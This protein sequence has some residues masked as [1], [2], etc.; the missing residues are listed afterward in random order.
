MIHLINSFRFS[1]D[2][3]LL[4]F[5]YLA[6][7]LSSFPTHILKSIGVISPLI[8]NIMLLITSILGLYF[9]SG[10]NYYIWNTFI[11]KNVSK[12]NFLNITKIY[13]KKFV[14]VLVFVL[15]IFAFSL[16]I[17]VITEKVIP[18]SMLIGM[19][20]RVVLFSIN[21]ILMTYM[22]SWIYVCDDK[23]YISNSLNFL[24]KHI[25]KFKEFILFVFI[26]NSINLSVNI[27]Y[28]QSH[29]VSQPNRWSVLLA[30]NILVY[31]CS[32]LAFLMSAQQIYTSISAN[33]SLQGAK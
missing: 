25:I 22:T 23:K 14:S 27:L 19:I 7:C 12:E 4:I 2:H 8:S 13:F 21:A 15:P 20:L 11:E 30:L 6:V 3:P 33:K 18:N 5:I 16:F 29:P 32:L 26:Y 10:I 9:I 28:L 17:V 24:F 31:F 1:V